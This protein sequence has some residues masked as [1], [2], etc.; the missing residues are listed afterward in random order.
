MELL[1]VQLEALASI[2]WLIHWSREAEL[3]DRFPVSNGNIYGIN[4]FYGMSYEF[5][6]CCKMVSKKKLL[7]YT[8]T[9]LWSISNFN[10]ALFFYLR[11]SSAV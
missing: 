4:V 8:D 7:N 2:G 1:S 10:C 6:I 9:Q 3:S 5:K 11:S